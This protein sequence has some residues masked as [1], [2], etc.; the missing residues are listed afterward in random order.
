MHA[1]IF[2]K[3][4]NAFRFLVLCLVLLILL[5]T[6]YL[7]F[8]SFFK[9]S[10][11]NS[12]NLLTPVDYPINTNITVSDIH[13]IKVGLIDTGLFFKNDE[14]N[15]KL[16]NNPSIKEGMKQYH[17]VSVAGIIAASGRTKYD[18]IG[19]IPGLNL[20]G[21]NVDIYKANSSDLSTAVD[22]LRQQNVDI[23][24]ISI[25]TNTYDSKL[26]NSVQRAIMDGIVIICSSG[27][28]GSY[29][30]N[31]PASFDIKGV[32]SVGALDNSFNILQSS[33]VNEMVD[34]YAPGDQIK[35]LSV[36]NNKLTVVK[37]SGTSF[38]APIITS[39]VVLIKAAKPKVSPADI[40]KILVASSIK[41]VANWGLEKKYINVV[42]FEKTLNMIGGK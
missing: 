17:G 9:L 40:E 34:I 42:D 23:I 15:I 25:G 7:F 31:Y 8:H 16:A 24:N 36:V 3:N 6:K 10:T 37:Q 28:S 4:T 33:T 35:T 29:L 19:F 2:R 5:L 21:Y 38:A 22:V 12:F 13:K 18:Y 39:L 11:L 26:F 20:I 32:V 1:N 14:I 27:N 41:Y 30:P